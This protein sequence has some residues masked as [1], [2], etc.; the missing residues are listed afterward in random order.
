MYVCGCFKGLWDFNEHI[1]S[2]L[3]SLYY[4]FRINNSF[5]PISAIES[6]N[7]LAVDKVSLVQ[8]DPRRRGRPF[9]NIVR[10]LLWW[11]VKENHGRPHVQ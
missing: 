7:S 4:N 2:L 8:G 6:Y 11:P 5:S 1:K 3:L 9:G 10:P